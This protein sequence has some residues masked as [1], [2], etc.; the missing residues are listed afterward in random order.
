MSDVLVTYELERL[1]K[2]YVIKNVPAKID[3]SGKHWFDREVMN[4]VISLIWT[5]IPL[6]TTE[7]HYFDYQ[8]VAK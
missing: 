8:K 2:L 3:D 5:G 7:T 6:R 1:N 4:Q